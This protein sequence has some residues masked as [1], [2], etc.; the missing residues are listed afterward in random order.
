MGHRGAPSTSPTIDVLLP[1]YGDSPLARA[2][3]RSVLS[4][5]DTGFQFLISDDGPFNPDLEGWLASQGSDTLTYTRN[6]K[7]LGVSGNFQ[8]LA[9]QS[10]ADFVVFMGADDLMLPSYIAVMR[11]MLDRHPDVAAIQPGVEVMDDHG[12][13]VHPLGDRIKRR[14][15][16]S[17]SVVLEGDELARGLCTGNWLYFPSILW[18]RRPVAAA[19]FRPDLAVLQD[20]AL[21]LGLILDGGSVAV[22]ND[23]VF[24]YRRHAQSESSRRAL[25]ARHEERAL[26]SEMS[27]AFEEHGWHAARRAARMRLT[28]RFHSLCNL[29]DAVRRA[30]WSATRDLVRLAV[31]S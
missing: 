23:L 27:T 4:Q 14:L 7:R 20:L 22:T 19:G 18:R 15:R 26:M 9:R 31:G 8:R 10:D 29:P 25:E 28:S 21:M 24:R 11:A 30:D 5:T 1:L 17:G 12:R 16:P 3:I 6:D 13:I 2:A